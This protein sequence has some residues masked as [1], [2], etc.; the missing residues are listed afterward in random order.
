[1]RAWLMDSYDGVE[2]LRLG[3][4]PDPQPGPAQVL[5]KV[6]VAALNPADA[7][8]ARRMY[9]AKPPLPHILGRDGV[10]DVLEVGPGV[11]N[12][13]EGE[14][15]GLLRCD[16]GVNVW[17]TLA[18]RVVVP[19]DSV[20]RIPHGWSL[21]EMAGAPLVFLT[22]WQALTQWTDPPAP[23][24]A[25]SLLL[26]TGASGGV[27]VASA[28]LGKSMALTV[29]ALSRSE[30]KRI[31]LKT[32][33]ADFVF[34]PADRNLVNTVTAAISPKKVDLAID[35]VGGVL[36]PQAIALLGDGG[37]ISVVGRSGGIVP[38]FNSASLLFRRIRIGGVSVGDYSAQAAH[39]AWREIVDRLDA[40]GQRP[41]IDT[42][43]PFEDVKTGFARLA[44]GP[45]GKVLVRI[46]D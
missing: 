26:I 43:V 36:L 28:L 22:A 38:E 34:D 14:T 7:F 25:G 42:I 20:V 21:E 27:G 2:S 12:V 33:G 45:M 39:T 18:E 46:A 19:M 35:S 31:R 9:P 3:E 24:P 15:V 29:A 17:G 30:D 1:M 8:L 6:R 4:V 10:G 40:I 5:L 13:H 16:V 32:L 37:R 23:P 41:Q 11:D 44:Q